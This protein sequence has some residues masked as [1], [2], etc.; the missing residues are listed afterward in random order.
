MSSNNNY[1]E[2]INRKIGKAGL[3]QLGYLCKE[4]NLYN[5]IDTYD[6]GKS[7]VGKEMDQ[8]GRWMFNHRFGGGHLWW[9]ELQTRP[10][11]Q[12]RETFEHLGSDFFTKAGLP[13]AFDGNSIRENK[14]LL[15]YFTKAKSSENWAMIN[16]FE[17][18]AGA[19]S[20]IFSVYDATHLKHGYSSDL[21]FAADGIFVS[22]NLMGG[23]IT[24]NPFLLIAG[25]MKTST[26]VRKTT[27][28]LGIEDSSPFDV[29]V[30]AMFELN[31]NYDVSVNQIIGEST[32][33]DFHYNDTS[34]SF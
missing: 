7:A 12:W 24:A 21:T 32:N 31:N 25:L 29:N 17:A 8:A 13:Y 28:Q 15:K 16:G 23:A 14:D 6:I 9:K 27:K 30:P 18:V 26:I 3:E 20:L 5:F 22:L 33:F 19:S 1:T 11:H 4:I 2:E 10:M 34:I